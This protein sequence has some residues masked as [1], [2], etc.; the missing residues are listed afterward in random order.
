[1][2]LT[3][4]AFIKALVK[5]DDSSSAL[6]TVASKSQF[7]H[8]VQICDVEFD[9][10]SIGWLREPKIKV[11]AVFASFQEE[12]VVAGMEISQSIESRVIIVV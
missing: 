1:M 4:H 10:R 6:Q 7:G 2:F 12:D 8:G 11:L 3:R 5:H 9:R